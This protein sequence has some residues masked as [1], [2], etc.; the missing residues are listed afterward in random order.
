MILISRTAAGLLI[1]R[2]ELDIEV[3][4]AAVALALGAIIHELTDA[5]TATTAAYARGHA[6]GLEDGRKQAE[7]ELAVREA[8]AEEVWG[9]AL[10]PAA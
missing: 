2:D 5:G 6:D 4:G 8:K 9:L 1:Q 7:R 10:A 3:E